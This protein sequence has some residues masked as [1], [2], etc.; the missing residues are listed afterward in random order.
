MAY[1]VTADSPKEVYYR[2]S[3]WEEVFNEPALI[4]RFVRLRE[5]YSQ[6]P[7]QDVASFM[8]CTQVGDIMYRGKD[9]V[10][11]RLRYF[12]EKTGK[13]LEFCLYR[14]GGLGERFFSVSYGD[15]FAP[16]FVDADKE[17]EE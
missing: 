4:N 6:Y 1:N 10:M 9:N 12:S 14:N 11:V 7:V 3:G 2:E 16:H 5:I 15:G 13:T 17:H 8:G